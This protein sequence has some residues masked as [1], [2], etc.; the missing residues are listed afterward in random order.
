MARKLQSDKWLFLATLALI[1]T[2]VV[3]VYSASA[4]VALERFQQPY[5]FVTRQIMW[6]AVG[7]AVLSIVMRIDYRTY[8]NDKLIWGLLGLVGLL[9]VAVLFSR[10]VNGTR[11]WFGIGGFGIQ[12][13]ELAKLSAIFFTALMLER[14]R[15]RINELGYALLPIGVIAGGLAALILLEPDFGTAVSLLAVI[16]VMTFAAGFSYRYVFGALLLALPALYVILM[17]ADYRRRRLLTF[18]D[19]WADPLGD[20]FQ[21]IQSLIAVGTGGVFGKGLM[22]GVQKLFYLP[23][24]HTDFI[25]A[26]ISE[27]TGLIGA[28]LVLLCFCLI[29][30]RGLRAALRAP[31]G[32]GAFLA[33][34]ITMMLVLQAFVNISVVL[35]LMPTKGIPLPLVSNGGSS[36]LINLLGVGVLLNI[37]QHSNIETGAA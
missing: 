21:V 15:H 20:G 27:E 25:Y 7:I 33:L 28:T 26:V 18:M 36:M 22:N 14:R 6:A 3:M 10:P 4:L 29:G 1:C 34:G 16:G 31:D 11:R 24:P 37:S 5:L 8:R 19:P 13:S 30:W 32:F 9:L 35:G 2:S 12:P 17:Q 23:E